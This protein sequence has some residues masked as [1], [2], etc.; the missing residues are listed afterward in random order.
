MFGF[1]VLFRFLS[2]DCIIVKSNYVPVQKKNNPPIF[3]DRT[4]SHQFEASMN[5]VFQNEPNKAIMT[6]IQM[7]RNCIQAILF[8]SQEAA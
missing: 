1:F 5:K 6:Y 7:H 3:S 8:L 2:V 4:H